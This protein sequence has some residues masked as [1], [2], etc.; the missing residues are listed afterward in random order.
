[1]GA[2][3]GPE[4]PRGGEGGKLGTFTGPYLVMG[5]PNLPLNMCL[6]HK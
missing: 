6:F 3:E 4:S 2:G 5:T 1:M